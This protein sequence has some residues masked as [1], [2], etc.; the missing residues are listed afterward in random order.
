MHKIP[1]ICVLNITTK[2]KKCNSKMLGQLDKNPDKAALIILGQGVC[3]FAAK[4]FNL[5]VCQLVCCF[6]CT[7]NTIHLV[8]LQNSII[9]C[10]KITSVFTVA[11]EDR[12]GIRVSQGT[13]SWIQ[14]SGNSFCTWFSLSPRLLCAF[15]KQFLRF[16][17]PQMLK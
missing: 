12:E 13:G 6:L 14:T 17:H 16:P 15:P 7:R 5:S 8:V 3:S 2:A 11:V 9:S 4:A 1:L 10:I